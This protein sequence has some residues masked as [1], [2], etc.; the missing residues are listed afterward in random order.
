MYI[1]DL[2]TKKRKKQEL[3]NEEIK[4][5]IFNY[6][7]NEI[8]EEQAAALLTLMYTNG[9][10]LNEMK[11]MISVI[12]ETGEEMELYR[13]SNKITEIHAI[14]G[15]SDKIIIILMTILGALNIETA[16]IVGREPGIVSKLESI[17]GYEIEKDFNKFKDNIANS[18]M[19]ILMEAKNLAP[20]EDRLY[21]LRYNI[22]C[23]NN[24]ELIALSIMS[25]KLAI[26]CKNILIEITTGENA[27]VKTESDAKKLAKYLV[28]IGK[29]LNRNVVCF[30]TDLKQPIGRCFGNN[31]E[32][33]EIIDFLQGDMNEE[34]KNK[35]LE[36]GNSIMQ[37]TGYGTNEKQNKK[38]ILETIES[39]QAYQR[40][41]QLVQQGNGN[42]DEKLEVAKKIVPIMSGVEG[43]VEEIDV[44]KIRMTGRYLGAIKSRTGDSIDRTAGIELVKKIGDTV[45]AGEIIAYLHTNNENKITQ[46][47][48]EVKEAFIISEKKISK[49]G[50]M[51][52]IV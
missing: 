1:R 32:I 27:Y 2:I 52:K 35:V 28:E 46:G 38:K 3:D 10:S 33:N 11:D 8:S 5:F 36:F 23:D 25:Q 22:A 31:M 44:N 24:M 16:K 42:I 17:N 50:L 14:G 43:Y 34:I 30:I 47:V 37:I 20:V 29:K 9:M 45:R 19:G 41:K 15:I 6:F 7:K 39:G 49:E 12:A 21:K 51:K 26:G 4:F 48:S 18:N 13:L 40:F